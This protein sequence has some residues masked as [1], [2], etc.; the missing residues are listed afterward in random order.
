MAQTLSSDGMSP[1]FSNSVFES[2][3]TGNSCRP[4]EPGATVSPPYIVTS[5]GLP[6]SWRWSCLSRSPDAVRVST[7]VRLRSVPT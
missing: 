5:S 7:Q 1:S 2:A 3:S 6:S 4:A